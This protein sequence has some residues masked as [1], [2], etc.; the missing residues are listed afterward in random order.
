LN[1]TQTITASIDPKDWSFYYESPVYAAYEGWYGPNA[2]GTV[3][4]DG[5]VFSF[6]IKEVRFGSQFISNGVTFNTRTGSSSDY[7]DRIQSRNIG[8]IATGK[9]LFVQNV[10]YTHT[11][12]GGFVPTLDFTQSLTQ[13]L[14]ADYVAQAYFNYNVGESSFIGAPEVLIVNGDTSSDVP[15]PTPFALLAIGALS[16]AGLRCKRYLK[17]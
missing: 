5:S 10:V 4:I 11:P 8:D 2:Q 12:G 9:E 16:I 1:Y 14:T 13:R 7:E 3:T 15:E 6:E 17:L